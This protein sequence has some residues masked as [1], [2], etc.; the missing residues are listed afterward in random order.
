[1]I[2]TNDSGLTVTEAIYLVQAWERN[3]RELAITPWLSWFPP[4]LNP[5]VKCRAIRS[6]IAIISRPT[7]YVLPS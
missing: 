7:M 3:S 6:V 5:D 4:D 1:M 2:E